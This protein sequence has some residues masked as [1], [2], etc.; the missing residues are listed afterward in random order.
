MEGKITFG[1]F[2]G[3]KR[4]E[5]GLTQK[6]LAEKLFITESAVSKWERGVSYPDITLV[7]ML[8][9]ALQVTEHE[10]ITASD[11]ISQRE[12]EHQAKKFRTIV[13]TYSWTFYVLYGA[14]LLVCFI[15][16]L[17]IGHTLSWFWV[18]LASIA[19]AFSLTSVP[20]LANKNRG[21]CTLGA[22]YLSLNLLLIVC[23]ILYGGNWLIITMISILFG[24]VVVFLP[25]ALSHIQ[26]PRPLSNHKALLCVASDTLLLFALV[27]AS[28][29]A[30]GA[31]G[32]AL[33]R[34]YLI[35]AFSAL[36]PWCYL[37][38]I[39]YLAIDGFFKVA[40]C[41]VAGGVFEFFCNG[42]INAILAGAPFV[43]PVVNL[44]NWRSDP[45]INGNIMLIIL[46]ALAA[47][48]LLFTAC[49]VIRTLHTRNKT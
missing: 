16:N 8:C 33:M 1:R 15:C 28:A 37:I 12:L 35:T 30:S 39:R 26:L 2:V 23:R 14:A 20:V 3:Q 17:A 49:G 9:E 11:D 29:L 6:E 38:I 22:F 45:A 41:L 32:Q 13:K 44:R 46:L 5:Q 21:L 31:G 10:L 36:L 27:T 7:P 18:V 48:A 40:L 25:Y 19:M 47:L 34:A 4:K 43:M 42:A 24:F